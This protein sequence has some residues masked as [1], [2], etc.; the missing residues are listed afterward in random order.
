MQC[1]A[2]INLR[3]LNMQQWLILGVVLILV[4]ITL[5]ICEITMDE[6]GTWMWL[7]WMNGTIHPLRIPVV[8]GLR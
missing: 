7:L 4:I 5:D 6:R 8:I 2:F 3:F 1:T